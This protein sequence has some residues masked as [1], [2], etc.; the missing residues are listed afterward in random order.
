MCLLLVILALALPIHVT[1]ADVSAGTQREIQTMLDARSAAVKAKDR[2]A[3]GATVD[4][5]AADFSIAQQL[6]FDRAAAVP[7]QSYALRLDLDEAPEFTRQ[8]DRERHGSSVLVALVEERFQVQGFDEHPMLN[9]LFFTLTKDGNRWLISSDSGLEDLGL[10]SSRQPWDFG[11]VNLSTSEH[12]MLVT[13]PQDSSSASTLLARA[14]AALPHV[15]RSWTAPWSKRVIIFVP[16]SQ[17]EL[18]RILDATF[19]VS[20]FVAVANSTVDLEEGWHPVT[21]VILNPGNFLRRTPATQTTILTHELVHVATR[22][23]SGPFVTSLVEEGIAQLAEHDRT[24]VTFSASSKTLRSHFDG[25]LPEDFDF[26]TGGGVSIRRSYAEA[27]SAIAYIIERYGL[28]KLTAFY[29][30]FGAAR[31][32]PGTARYH[33]DR[34]LRSAL[35]LS[36]ADFEREWGAAVRGR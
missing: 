21:R 3:F 29:N 18:E 17:R 32:E 9:P 30:A 33:L 12:F 16:A 22:P 31:I 10:F 1:G 27:L 36:L 35:G 7:F 20:N 28:E 13:H 24:E 5:R 4:P 14:E 19:D 11:P 6:W 23:A 25:T 26:I 8:R 34:S 15:E 2:G